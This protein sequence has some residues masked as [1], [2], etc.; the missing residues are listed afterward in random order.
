MDSVVVVNPLVFE[1]KKKALRE[2]GLGKLHVVA[3]Y[4]KTLT[5]AFRDGE[6]HNS[7]IE[8]IR[9]YH[10][11]SDEYVK[12]AYGLF[13][14][15]HS[16]ETDYSLSLE[17]RKEKMQEWWSTHVKVIA[18]H[19]LSRSIME[20]MIAEQPSNLRKGLPFF[21]TTL[22]RH[23][24][25]ILILSAGVTDL[26]EGFLQ[27]EGLFFP[28]VHV[29]SN[30]YQYD[31]SGCV[32]GYANP[33]IHSLNKNET[34]VRGTPY[35]KSARGRGNVLLLGDSLGDAEML[36]GFDHEVVIKIGFLNDKVDEQIEKFKC[37]FD[38]VLL[39]DASMDFV[40]ELLKEIIEK[41]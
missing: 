3:D 16:F 4:D 25:P 14:T 24:V 17:E 15:Y 36:C 6:K 18:E 29:I 5:C 19:G 11:L 38:V 35:E 9:K 22:N 26:I 21:I 30:K 37:L 23:H 39:N 7:L 27:K 40:N 41:D 28:N 10:Y 1:Q 20:K 31:S 13:D 34:A 32:T 8:L 33:I 12:K 2:G